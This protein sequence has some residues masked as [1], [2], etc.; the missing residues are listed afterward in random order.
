MLSAIWQFG[1]VLA[2]SDVDLLFG[3]N[4][5]SILV[6]G[7]INL[8]IAGGACFILHSHTITF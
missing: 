7:E 1:E 4:T 8:G 3:D 6:L 5:L 2:S